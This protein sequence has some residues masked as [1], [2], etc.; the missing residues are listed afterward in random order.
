ARCD[1]DLVVHRS[2]D[3]GSPRDPGSTSASSASTSAGSA[4]STAGRPAP[5]P[6]TRP[7]G[8]IPCSSSRAPRDTVSA[9]APTAPATSLTP[10]RPIARASAPSSNR[11]CR[12]FRCGLISASLPANRS[13][14]TA[15]IAIPQHYRCCPKQTCLIYSRALVGEIAGGSA[16]LRQQC[17]ELGGLFLVQ[18]D[19]A[20]VDVGQCHGGGFLTLPAG[21]GDR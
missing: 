13:R 20:E 9:L 6:R 3:S 8:S 5:A 11:H 7:S 14:S 16:Y 12:S 10:P 1:V 15:M 17:G 18:P 2:G 19:E 21:F 4:C